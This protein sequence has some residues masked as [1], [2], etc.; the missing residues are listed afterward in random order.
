[1]EAYKTWGFVE[2]PLNNATLLGQ[3]LYYHRL[4]DFQAF[5]DLH[6]GDVS[7]AV[8]ALTAGVAGVADPFD[9][10]P[11]ALEGEQPRP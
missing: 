3:M 11:R 8:A 1:M 6:G 7:E 2:R 9:L 10:L 5:L 4:A